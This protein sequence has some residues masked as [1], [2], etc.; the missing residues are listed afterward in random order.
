MF[1]ES[2]LIGGLVLEDFGTIAGGM[3]AKAAGKQNQRI[4]N[5]QST[6][7]QQ[8]AAFD[9][10]RIKQRNKMGLGDARAAIGGSGTTASGSNLDA[11]AFSANQGE[12]DALARKYSGD[13]ESLGL[14][15]QGAVARAQGDAAFTGAIIKTA[16]STALG[17]AYGS[18][19]GFFG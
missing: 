8:S 15:Q 19:L 12:L 4:L 13:L 16:A 6:A 5:M 9:V 14:R 18:K 11:L 1:M 2:L 17:A 10:A 3:N 7:A